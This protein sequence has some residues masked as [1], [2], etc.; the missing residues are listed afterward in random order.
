MQFTHNAII[1]K[2]G[3]ALAL[4]TLA[5]AAPP[6]HAQTYLAAGDFSATNN[7]NGVWGYGYENTLG[8][9]F[10]IY[11]NQYASPVASIKGWNQNFGSNDPLVQK[12]F[13]STQNGY[14]D[15][16]LQPGQL[17]FHPGPSDQFSIVRFTAP[18]A[19]SYSLSSG[20]T[21]VTTDG[22]TTDVH[23]LKEGTSLFAG[24]VSGT[25]NAPTSAPTFSTSF[26]LKSR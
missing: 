10:N 4:L 1:A 12:N 16:V 20:F 8:G 11:V 15:I 13:G 14:G 21:P 25:Y 18:K 3:L 6:A 17:M 19:G 24:N 2:A 7:P 5:A 26:L 9:A 23:V 22:T